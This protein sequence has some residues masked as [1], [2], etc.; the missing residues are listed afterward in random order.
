MP[1]TATGK[2]AAEAEIDEEDECEANTEE[3][4][5]D[6]EERDEED[7]DEEIEDEEAEAGEVEEQSVEENAPAPASPRRK[8]ATAQ[9]HSL[10]GALLPAVGFHSALCTSRGNKPSHRVKPDGRQHS[11]RRPSHLRYFELLFVQRH[12]KGGVVALPATT[13]WCRGMS[14]T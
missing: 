12:L 13:V 14:D 7:E 4:E 2:C 10:G 1:S 11:D 8:R 3:C 9:S 5:E 6:D